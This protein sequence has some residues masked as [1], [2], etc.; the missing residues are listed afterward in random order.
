[1]RLPAALESG[2]Y[3]F[4]LQREIPLGEITVRA[5]E[6]L[7]TPPDVET[8]V[9]ATFGDNHGNPAITLIG[10]TQPPI[11]NP[12]SLTVVWHSQMEFDISYRVFIHLVD[13]TGRIISQSDSEPAGWTR[14]TTSWVPGEYIVDSHQLSLPENLPD[15]P[16]SL[17]VG[18]YN[19]DTGERLQAGAAEFVTLP[20][21]LE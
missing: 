18:L 15:G 20:L 8:A 1:L 16:L 2:P 9:H 11:S 19:P 14:P 7:F 4:R 12:Q 3:Y 10:Y 5:P 21:P 6:R 13:E 17:R